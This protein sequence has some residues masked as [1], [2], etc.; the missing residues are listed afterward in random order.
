MKIHAPNPKKSQT[1]FTIIELMIATTV[2]SVVLLVVSFGIINI[3]R[4]YYRSITIARTQ[5]TAR[6]IVEEISRSAQFLNSLSIRPTG[7][8]AGFICLGTSRYTYDVNAQIKGT[9]RHALYLDRISSADPCNRV[10]STFPNFPGGIEPATG[11]ELLGE[12]MRLLALEITPAGQLTTIR[13]KVAYG[14][15]ELLTPYTN[16][17]LPIG[18]SVTTA[19]A[20]DAQC[21]SGVAGSN[22]CATA[23][24]RITVKSRIISNN[25]PSNL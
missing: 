10:S 13:V 3:A 19:E 2:F 6:S 15:N 8:G 11:R 4:Q 21:Y 7:G 22:F 9:R 14:D 12:N 18:G 23:D 5:E 20:A 17:G 16:R 25:Q 24:L 1:G